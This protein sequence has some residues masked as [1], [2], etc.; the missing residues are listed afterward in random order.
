M[1]FQS[2]RDLLWHLQH[3]KHFSHPRWV[4]SATAVPCPRQGTGGPACWP[5]RA[6]VTGSA[7]QGPTVTQTPTQT[8]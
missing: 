2:N 6:V 8:V 7:P 5:S 4:T 1:N 3:G